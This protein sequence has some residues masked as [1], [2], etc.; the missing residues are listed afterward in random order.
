MRSASSIFQRMRHRI[1]LQTD[2]MF[3]WL[4]VVQWI[5][6]V[7]LAVVIAPFAYDRGERTLHPHVIAAIAFGGLVNVLPLTLITLQ[8]GSALTRHVVAASQMLWS[9]LLIMITGGR[10]ETH[11]HVFG[12]LAFLGFYR[13][14]RILVTA[15]VVVALDHLVRGLWWPDSVYGLNNPEWWR[16]LEHAGWVV[17]EVFVLTLGARRGVDEMQAAAAREARLEETNKIIE[18]EV[19]ART[20]DLAVSMH[21]YRALVENMEAIP[22]E[23]DAREGR[24]VYIAPQATR[25]FDCE[26]DELDASFL[27]NS[28]HTDDRA[29]VYADLAAYASEPHPGGRVI[30]L[31]VVAKSGRILDVRCFLSDRVDG[32][33]LRGIMLDVTRQTQLERELREA[34]KLESVGKLAAGVA[35]EIN[36]PIQYIAASIQFVRDAVDDLHQITGTLRAV[37]DRVID[38]ATDRE[39]ALDA[40]AQA[41]ETDLDYLLAEIPEALDRALEGTNRVAGIVRSMKVLA[42]PDPE[43]LGQI[44]VNAALA[45]ALTMARNEYKYV[46]DIETRM[47]DLPPVTCAVGALNQVFLNIIVNAAHAIADAVTS[48]GARGTLSVT[49]R[50]VADHAVISIGDTGRGIPETI[51]DRIFD[52]FFTTKPVGKGTG[53]GL[54]ISRSIVEKQGGLLTFETQL[55]IGTTFHI[56][57]PIDVR[58]HVNGVAA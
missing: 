38:G 45:N 11:F 22:F 35:H 26:L 40:R 31:R 50:R 48:T 14:W 28:V 1:Y 16:F 21:R 54:A 55:G 32:R 47:E 41:D 18:S 58:E 4:L 53:Q 12:S 33:Y 2:R 13:D 17:F 46:A 42:H 36:T 7:V 20:E 9:A 27:A 37:N 19:Q 34:Q 30:D 44:D 24:N 6:A 3:L 51:R 10:I 5:F 57:I 15:T 25:L 43:Q 52:P 29:R 56:K 49:S 39:L 23:Y 8:P